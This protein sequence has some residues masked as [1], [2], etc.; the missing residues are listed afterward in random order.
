MWGV[1]GR[2]SGLGTVVAV[3]VVVPP[4]TVLPLPLWVSIDDGGDERVVGWRGIDVTMVD[5]RSTCCAG[6]PSL[7]RLGAEAGCF[8]LG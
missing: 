4:L 6:G 3:G 8:G 2:C 5:W 1:S 7:A